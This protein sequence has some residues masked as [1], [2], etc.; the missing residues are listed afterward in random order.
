MVEIIRLKE[1]NQRALLKRSETDIETVL[2]EVRKIVERVKREG[3]R[4]LFQLE[5]E[6]DKSSLKSLRVG[7]REIVEA[8]EKVGEKAVRTLRKI[9]KILEKFHQKMLPRDWKDKS[10]NG[11][12]TG[13]LVRPL[14]KV[15]LY[16]P[17]G[18]TGYPSTVLMSGI[19]AKV[20]G[21]EELYMCT[22][23]KG[24]SVNPYVLVA[25]DIVGID[26]VFK[27]GGAQA[28]AAM[29]Y[30]TKT[31]P[32]V[33]KIIGPGNVYVQAAK[34][35]VAGEVEIDFEAGPSEVMVIA[36]DSASANL[37]ALE[38]L[39][40][41]EHDINSSAILVTTSG[42][43][44]VEVKR[45]LEERMDS[46]TVKLSFS[47]YS[48]I[49]LVSNLKKGMEFANMYAPEHLV[50]MVRQPKKWLTEVKNAGEVFLGP[51]SAVATGDFVLGPSHVLPTGGKAK[52]RSGLTVFD[53]LKLIPYHQLSREG[54]K[55]ISV[56]VQE[57][58][59]MEELPWHA[60]SVKERLS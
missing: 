1:S 15:G 48:K 30:G 33:D 24:G 41:A 37:V 47:R 13:I 49:V 22:P 2:P 11:G 59:S 57:M 52:F 27:V 54:L 40:Q 5:K 46:E 39:A 19:P 25:A 12:V 7:D 31:I 50:L 44:A 26:A 23:P 20:A 29:A 14:E 56:L 3:D 4:A 28:I 53:F 9:A 8:Y 16:V 51:Y 45:I 6:L 32:K 36:D 42:K 38:L 21:V 43:L 10:I 60:K 35:L 17:G 18:R 34:R 58:A 55:K